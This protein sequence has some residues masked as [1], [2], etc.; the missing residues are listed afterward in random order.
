MLKVQHAIRIATVLGI[1]LFAVVI[2]QNPVRAKEKSPFTKIANDGSDVEVTTTFGSKPHEWACARD[3]VSGLTWEIKTTDGGLRDKNWTFTPYDSNSATNHGW[4]GYRDKTSG[5]CQ[6]ASMNE[7]SCNTEAYVKAVNKI[8]LCGYSD[9]RLPTL[10]ELIHV[11]K[12]TSKFKPQST[13]LPLPN[14]A[15][16]WYWTGVESVGA[17]R[18]SRVVLLPVRGQPNFYDGSYMV[19]VVRGRSSKK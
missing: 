7:N 11:A 12:E 3:E 2:M 18:F 17:T 10:K 9:W 19:L 8:R 1:Y 16:G 13:S 4:V 15:S 6:R 5:K 14:T